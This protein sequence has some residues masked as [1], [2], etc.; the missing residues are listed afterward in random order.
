MS[1]DGTVIAYDKYGH[2]PAVVISGGT[3][4]DRSQQA[5]VAQLLATEFTVFNFD[6]RGRG[7]TE[8]KGPYTRD[9]EFEDLDAMI[10]V[11]GGSAFVYGTSG[12]GVM[13]LL[14]ASSGRL[15]STIK[16]MVLWE[17]PFVLDGHIPSNYKH[18]L[19]SMLAEGQRGDMVELFMTSAV[20]MPKEVVASMR[21][22]PFWPAQEALAHTL[23]YD[24]ILMG[25]YSIPKDR[26]ARVKVPTLVIDG[27]TI[28]FVTASCE[29]VATAMPNA[30]R[31]TLP[32][33]PHNVDPNA[34]APAIIEFFKS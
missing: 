29:A 34:I 18:Q 32:G 12:P 14:A 25:D 26:I 5:D 8:L 19:E 15:V 13:A 9:G 22:M 33:Q 24:A 16:K 30:K 21:Q 3:V 10:H 11:A 17:P 31:L 1:K 4:G 23:V 28:P 7:E 6:R 2:G 27:G 20:G